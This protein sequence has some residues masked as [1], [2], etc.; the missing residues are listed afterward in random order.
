MHGQRRC[1]GVDKYLKLDKQPETAIERCLRDQHSRRAARGRGGRLQ[2]AAA[3]HTSDT[4][5]PLKLV[6]SALKGRMVEHW[7]P[8]L[9]AP[10]AS[11]AVGIEELARRASSEC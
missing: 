10:S 2:P 3:V 4:S 5:R 8:I 1:E 7:K 9:M 6:H 11:S